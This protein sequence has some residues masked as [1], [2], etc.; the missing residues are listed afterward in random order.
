MGNRNPHLSCP[1]YK[2]SA[3]SCARCLQP[4]IRA[5]PRVPGPRNRRRGTRGGPP[6]SGPRPTSPPPTV[7]IGWTFLFRACVRHGLTPTLSVPASSS[8]P[9]ASPMDPRTNYSP[10]PSIVPFDIH[11]LSLFRQ[12]G[13]VQRRHP[14]GPL[15]S[16]PPLPDALRVPVPAELSLRYILHPRFYR[17]RCPPG[18]GPLSAGSARRGRAR[19]GPDLLKAAGD[20]HSP[21]LVAL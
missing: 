19:R 5:V 3:H 12:C 18:A 13:P 20:H 1:L 11:A 7:G 21:C 14:Q 8:P 2:V 6:V 10:T 4:R 17:L 15:C 16:L 9:P